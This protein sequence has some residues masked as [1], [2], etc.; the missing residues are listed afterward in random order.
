[1]K[2][3]VLPLVVAL[4]LSAS[5]VRGGDI[6]LPEPKMDGGKP[7]FE[8]IR[9]RTSA[10]GNA[11]PSG[12][13]SDGELSTILWAAS[14]LNRPGKG[15]TIPLGMSTEPYVKIYVASAT[16]LY[17]YSWQ[18]QSLK[19]V[20]SGDVRTR[21]NA[22]PF[23][24]AASHIL[25]FVTDREPLERIGRLSESWDEWMDVAV[26]AM[27]QNAYLAADSLGI[28]A[29]YIGIMDVDFLRSALSIP[30][31]EKPVCLLPLGKR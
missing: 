16:G 12:K 20:S 3:C 24:K 19:E 29:R 27:T 5:A 26:G 7:V 13:V 4:L 31:G 14:G 30:A 1:M 10:L 8:A 28:G 21:L 18:D 22:Q 11:F 17:L 15:W 25:I 9:D 2:K 23:A 6:K